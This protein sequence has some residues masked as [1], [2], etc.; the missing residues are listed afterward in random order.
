MPMKYVKLVEDGQFFIVECHEDGS[1]TEYRPFEPE[2]KWGGGWFEDR[3]DWNWKSPALIIEVA[4][5]RTHLRG[6]EGQQSDGQRV[7]LLALRDH[8]GKPREKVPSEDG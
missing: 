2:S 5:Q 3:D 6:G 8:F 4:G 1:L 7:K